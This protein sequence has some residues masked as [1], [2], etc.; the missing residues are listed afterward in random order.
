MT[1]GSRRVVV[2]GVGLLLFVLAAGCTRFEGP[3]DFIA[4]PTSGKMPLVVSFEPTFCGAIEHY[5]WSFGDG[6]TSTERSPEHTYTKAGTYT[7]TLLVT[8]QAGE[9]LAAVKEDYITVRSGMQAGRITP[10][11][12][13]E[14]GVGTV[15]RCLRD[16]SLVQALDMSI[17][18]PGD[19]VVSGS[20]VY[21]A[22]TGRGEIVAHDLVTS[23]NTVL[24]SGRYDPYGVAA[25]AQRGKLYW[26]ELYTNPA[27]IDG[28]VKSI[29]LTGGSPASVLQTQGH[30]YDIVYDPVGGRLYWT[31][32]FSILP[33]SLGG[34]YGIAVLNPLTG[35]PDRVVSGLAYTPVG[36]AVDGV[37]GKLYWTGNSAVHRCNLNG[38]GVETIV[39]GADNPHGIAVDPELGK[40]YW[41]ENGRIR[42]ANL[43]GTVVQTILDGLG[44]IIGLS[45]G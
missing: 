23:Q 37:N 31:Q 16:G 14:A 44:Q 17:D 27:G 38:T 7:V 32:H 29:P 8:P 45:L 34:S 6:T 1:R 41:G 36:I 19:V 30:P 26:T 28:M 11:Y 12:W 20:V 24:A 2:A 33:R 18:E 21:W 22:D 5:V 9:P 13:T 42:Q 10:I 35:L 3:V 4:D 39:S 43:D 40:V 25:D 15:Q